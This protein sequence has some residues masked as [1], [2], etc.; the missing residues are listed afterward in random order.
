MAC[1]ALS[2]ASI[3]PASTCLGGAGA[4][5]FFLSLGTTYRS[6]LTG[7]AER[8]PLSDWLKVGRPT[9]CDRPA[10]EERSSQRRARERERREKSEREGRTLVHDGLELV[11]LDDA[12]PHVL[13]VEVDL[14]LG[15]VG[16][17][18]RVVLLGA[19][20]GALEVPLALVVREDLVAQADREAHGRA[21]A[22]S[23]AQ[24]LPHEAH[25]ALLVRPA[26]GRVHL[27]DRVHR[28]PER[29]EEAAVQAAERR[30]L[31]RDDV[32]HLVRVLADA[33]AEV[34]AVRDAG[35][36]LEQLDLGER[37]GEE[38]ER[39]AQGRGEV[40]LVG[41]ADPGVVLQDADLRASNERESATGRGARAVERA[42]T[43]GLV[44][45]TRDIERLPVEQVATQRVDRDDAV[46]EQLCA[47]K[48]L[49]M[50]SARLV[51][52]GGGLETGTAR[53]HL[54]VDLDVDVE[55]DLGAE[56]LL[57]HPRDG[58]AAEEPHRERVVVRVLLHV[59]GVPVRRVRD[60]EDKVEQGLVLRASEREGGSGTRSAS[61]EVNEGPPKG[62][63]AHLLRV[64]LLPEDAAAVGE[65]VA[66][67]RLEVAEDVLEVA[68]DLLGDLDDL[69]AAERL[70][71]LHHGR[72][73]AL[74]DARVGR[75]RGDGRCRFRVG[76]LRVERARRCSCG[77]FGGR[78]LNSSPRCGIEVRRR[79]AA[80]RRR[81]ALGVEAGES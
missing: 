74:G 9:I 75:R 26:V 40:D 5:H 51:D 25:A 32:A 29:L 67:G 64:A 69:V 73:A 49:D 30:Q 50:V 66:D 27:A 15:T 45:P 39:G 42:G 53:T 12:L 79:V 48:R 17:V 4:P 18:V 70:G 21:R 61:E 56:A 14:V 63:R 72:D 33:H 34:A 43:Y 76:L 80:A 24:V 59:D 57:L 38:E 62:R 44:E 19:Q 77:R 68:L 16:R 6:D 58:V 65:R 3:R 31:R 55:P 1:R 28:L 13:H 10:G 60:G 11:V 52:S 81:L 8:M 71:E 78:L 35:D 2:S 20:H 36:L 41:E 23:G 37:L 7:P 54:A 47:S 22:H 46:L